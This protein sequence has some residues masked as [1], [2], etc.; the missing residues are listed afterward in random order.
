[1]FKILLISISILGAKENELDPQAVM[2]KSGIT[3]RQ[4]QDLRDQLKLS[5]DSCD[6]LASE[7]EP[8]FVRAREIARKHYQKNKK[9]ISIEKIAIVL[10]EFPTT[11]DSEILRSLD[12]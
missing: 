8:Y 3:L 1:M 7:Y 2:A 12:K 10:K 11:T 9:N 6:L 4:C 5:K